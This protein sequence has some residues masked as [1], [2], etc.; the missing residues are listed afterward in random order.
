[1][2]YNLFKLVSVLLILVT[3]NVSASDF[4]NRVKLV[5]ARFMSFEVIGKDH[6]NKDRNYPLNKPLES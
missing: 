6:E 5:G 4:E 2:L 1:M 3:T